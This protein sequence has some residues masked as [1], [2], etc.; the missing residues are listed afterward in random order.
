MKTEAPDCPHNI[1]DCI[2]KCGWFDMEAQGVWHKNVTARISGDTIVLS[3][4]LDAD[5]CAVVEGGAAPTAVR[6]EWHPPAPLLVLTELRL[7]GWMWA[8]RPARGLARGH[9]LQQGQLPCA[10]LRAPALRR[11]AH[12]S[13]VQSS[14]RSVHSATPSF[15]LVD[16]VERLQLPRPPPTLWD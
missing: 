7:A 10:A 5:G 3:P 15:G 8:G 12:P 1:D 9:A 16:A 4:P 6:C 11:P 14:I 2:A 13:R